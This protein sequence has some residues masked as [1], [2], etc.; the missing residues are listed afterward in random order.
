[1]PKR[2]VSMYLPGETLV[3][4]QHKL[5]KQWKHWCKMNGLQPQGKRKRKLQDW[6]YLIGQGYVWRVTMGRFQRGDSIAEFDRWA[7]CGCLLP[8]ATAK[9]PT[10][11]EQF[12]N[13][14]QC[15]LRL[16]EEFT[17]TN[18]HLII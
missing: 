5:P 6:T 12:T 16:P 2:V 15:H 11:L 4:Q 1:M 10:S 14:V 9:V 7:L 3:K 18:R 13:I 8:I 17:Q